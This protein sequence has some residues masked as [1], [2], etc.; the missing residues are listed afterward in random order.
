MPAQQCTL[1][2][3]YFGGL[4]FQ[5]MSICEKGEKLLFA[6]FE[7]WEILTLTRLSSW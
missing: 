1:F 6:L 7:A 4:Q 2:L 5:I 3:P